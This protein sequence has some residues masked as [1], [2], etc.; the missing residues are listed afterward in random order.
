MPL[1][2]ESIYLENLIRLGESDSNLLYRTNTYEESSLGIY[3]NPDDD[4]V[5]VNEAKSISYMGV[6]IKKQLAFDL[7]YI[8]LG[9]FIILI[10]ER[11]RV[12][13]GREDAS[14]PMSL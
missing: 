8:V 10:A 7:W 2:S 12:A 6:H 4:E 13:N 5:N 3:S 9:A 11:D 1:A 14:Y